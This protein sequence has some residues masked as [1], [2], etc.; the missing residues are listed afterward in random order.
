MN[1]TNSIM[2]N[3]F[4]ALVPALLV[5]TYFWGWNTLLLFFV[6]VFSALVAEIIVSRLRNHKYN[7][8]ISNNSALVTSLIITLSLPPNIPF[9]I[10]LITTLFAIIIGKQVY[11]GM[12]QNIFNPAMVGVALFIITYPQFLTYWAIPTDTTLYEAQ[13]NLQSFIGSN[14]VDAFTQATPLTELKTLIQ[15]GGDAES[16]ANSLAQILQQDWLAWLVYNGAIL[17][18]GVYLLLRKIIGLLL[19]CFTILGFLAVAVLHHLFAG[20]EQIVPT[21]TASLVYGSLIFGAFFIITDPVTTPQTKKARIIYA[22]LVGALIYTIR[23]F[24]NYNDGVAFAIL[25]G[26][27]LVPMFDRTIT[28]KEFGK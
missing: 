18:G 11:G 23:A 25:L 10:I 7:A 26:N 19:P 9:Y 4:L 17:L 22:L 13:Q 8:E 28:P 2:L 15:V 27:L 24:T 3:V 20:S 5:K 14:Q 12:G 16:K 6:A 1:K 21:Y